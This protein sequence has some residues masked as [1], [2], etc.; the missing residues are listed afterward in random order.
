M[1][2]VERA[3]LQTGELVRVPEWATKVDWSRSDVEIGLSVKLSRTTVGR[4]RALLGVEN[5]HRTRPLATKSARQ[6]N[7][8]TGQEISVPHWAVGVDWSMSDTAIAQQVGVSR[9]R[10]G[11]VRRKLG[12]TGSRVKEDRVSDYERMRRWD[13]IRENASKMTVP[14]LMKRTGYSEQHVRTLLSNFGLSAKRMD[15]HKPAPRYDW[16]KVNWEKMSNVE[17]AALVGCSPQTVA[18]RR[19]VYKLP[20]GPR[21][22]RN[23]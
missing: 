8:E 3:N 14:E 7:E 20:K 12:K 6:V 17:V 10:V 15:R 5:V 1:R 19:H 23:V 22:R 9:A 11:T 16:S 18:N 2:T 13:F 4:V 21:G